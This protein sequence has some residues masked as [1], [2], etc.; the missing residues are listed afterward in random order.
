MIRIGLTGGIGSGKSTTAAVFS[1]L[2]IPVYDSDTAAKAIMDTDKTVIEK[3]KR[4][5]GEESYKNGLPDRAYIA[6]IVFSDKEKLETLN[7]IVHP[8]VRENYSQWAGQH[9]NCAYTVMESAILIES[10]F[11]DEVDKVVVVSAPESLRIERVMQRD[12]L[13]ADVVKA[14]IDSQMSDEE[15]LLHA[16]YVLYADEQNLLI[17]QI[18]ELDRKLRQ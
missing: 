14:R 6:K 9:E 10:G 13:P 8:A 2:G 1:A 7:G 17:P 11:N 4:E 16:D 18:L 5:F 3:L 12:S 15:R